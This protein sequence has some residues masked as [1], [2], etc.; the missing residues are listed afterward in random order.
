VLG[1]DMLVFGSDRPYALPHPDLGLGEAGHHAI[2]VT[3]PAR[4]LQGAG[5]PTIHQQGEE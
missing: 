4:L 2:R 1:I 5:D 3:N